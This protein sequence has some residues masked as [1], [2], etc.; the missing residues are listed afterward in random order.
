[1][2]GSP[3]VSRKGAESPRK[4]VE[5]PQLDPEMEDSEGEGLTLEDIAELDL[6]TEASQKFLTVS[7]TTVFLMLE[8]FYHVCCRI[9]V[10]TC[11]V[12]TWK[13]LLV[14]RESWEPPVLKDWRQRFKT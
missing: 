5:F 14:T 7:L 4:G 9:W 12:S 11:Q 3:L 13:T 8:T 2:V 10:L 1:M 6:I